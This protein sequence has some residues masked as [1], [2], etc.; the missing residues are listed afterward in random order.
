MSSQLLGRA[1]QLG[2]AGEPGGATSWPIISMCCTWDP[3]IELIEG[4]GVL[5]TYTRRLPTSF[6]VLLLSWINSLIKRYTREIAEPRSI[7][8]YFSLI[9]TTG[10]LILVFLLAFL[11]YNCKYCSFHVHNYSFIFCAMKTFNLLIPAIRSRGLKY[12]FCN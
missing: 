8:S 7:T 5:K 10:K 9:W 3:C 11:T 1:L 2:Q 4:G 12:Y 6:L